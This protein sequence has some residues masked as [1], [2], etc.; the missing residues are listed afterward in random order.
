M[1]ILPPVTHLQ[2]LILEALGERGGEG[3]VAGAE[4]RGTLGDHGVSRTLPAFY[5]LMG[6]LEKAGLVVGHYAPKSVNGQKVRE[7]RYALTQEGSDAH[8]ATC[9]FYRSRTGARTQEV[10]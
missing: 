8:E 9:S 3:D 6:R 10:S 7:R 1:S 2:F 4:V 5:E